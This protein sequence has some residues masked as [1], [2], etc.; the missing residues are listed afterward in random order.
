M[1][2]ARDLR[3]AVARQALQASSRRTPAGDPPAIG[4]AGQVTVL[5]WSLAVV[6]L[7]PAA[8]CVWASVLCLV[9]A[10][11]IYPLRWRRLLRLRW[12]VLLLTLAVPPLLFAGQADYRI[13]GVG[14]SAEGAQAALQV[15]LRLL[16]MLVVVEGF[17]NAVDVATMAGLFERIG[18]Q[19]L[20]FALGVALNLLPALQGSAANAWHSLWLRGGLR[21][22][23]WRALRL[24]LVTVLCNALRRAEEIALAAEARA[25]SPERARPGPLQAGRFDRL[26]VALAGL[27]LLG[28]CVLP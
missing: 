24:L 22:R 10:V 28:F 14:I 25:F 7:V 20:G 11:A 3:R 18:F 19:G 26:A 1:I 17:T 4:T 5:A 8:R 13:L 2:H 23:R 27:S 12:L 16:V 21:R 15:A 9:V 6:M